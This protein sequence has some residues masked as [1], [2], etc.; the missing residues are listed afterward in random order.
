[1]LFLLPWCLGTNN[2]WWLKNKSDNSENSWVR[3]HMVTLLTQWEWFIK[4][5][6]NTKIRKVVAH[7]GSKWCAVCSEYMSHPLV[8]RLLRLLPLLILIFFNTFLFFSM[9]AEWAQWLIRIWLSRV[10][11]VSTVDVCLYGLSGVQ[12]LLFSKPASSKSP[13]MP[14]STHMSK[15]NSTQGCRWC[16][17]ST[18]SIV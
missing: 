18:C 12:E 2:C 4:C 3:N 6:H 16:A 17:L 8:S 10:Q 5:S 14:N 1:M 11:C 9:L 7:E 13:Q 15:E